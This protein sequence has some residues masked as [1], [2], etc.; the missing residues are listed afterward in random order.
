MTE[1]AEET[2]HE[3]AAK[4]K[5]DSRNPKNFKAETHLFQRDGSSDPSGAGLSSVAQGRES[6]SEKEQLHHSKCK[7]AII[8]CSFLLQKI[9]KPSLY[10]FK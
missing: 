3:K 7:K 1:K 8:V 10:F 9:N 4:E 6:P 5:A 2:I